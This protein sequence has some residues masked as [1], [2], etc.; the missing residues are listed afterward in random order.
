[1]ASSVFNSSGEI[2][3][4]FTKYRG[5][6]IVTTDSIGQLLIGIVKRLNQVVLS[7]QTIIDPAK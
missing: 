4:A 3:A 7:D 1:M 6:S 5:N 2:L